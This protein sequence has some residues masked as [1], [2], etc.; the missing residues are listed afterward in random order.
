MTF[1]TLVR[2][3]ILILVLV[4]AGLAF[5]SYGVGGILS[6]DWINANIRHN[7]F[8]GVMIFFII[9]G[10]FIAGG[11]PRLSSPPRDDAGVACVGRDET[12]LDQAGRGERLS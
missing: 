12:R 11:F 10:I 8:T 3:L 1:R 2:G 7:G 5:K 9:V 6:E 4:G